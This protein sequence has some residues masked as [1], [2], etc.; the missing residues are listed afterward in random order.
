MKGRTKALLGAAFMAIAFAGYSAVDHWGKM[1]SPDL[2]AAPHGQ[3][4]KSK[5]VKVAK[6]FAYGNVLC[7]ER[8]TAWLIP[9]AQ[10]C[11]TFNIPKEMY[12]DTLKRARTGDAQKIRDLGLYYGSATQRYPGFQQAEHHDLSAYWIFMAAMSGDKDQ[13]D[14]AT[15]NL[16]NFA[17]KL[18]DHD[19][20]K[21]IMLRNME[22]IR[23]NSGIK[24][25][26]Y[27][28]ELAAEIERLEASAK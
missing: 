26:E 25:S 2:S 18:N 11:V 5:P 7:H 27:D 15:I 21:R 8:E 4:Q 12:S 19:P 6:N 1:K 20:R 16:R 3:S 13:Q 10:A 22:S 28:Q 9:E 23:K 14:R 24:P 17:D